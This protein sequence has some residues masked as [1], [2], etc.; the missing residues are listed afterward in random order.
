MGGK[1]KFRRKKTS[2][3]GQGQRRKFSL[4]K[5]PW[6]LVK[7]YV[8]FGLGLVFFF[9]LFA[10]DFFFK[11]VMEPFTAFVALCSSQILNIFGSWT[12]VSGTHL[13]SSDYGINVV[14]GCNGAFATAILLSGII[15][16]PSRIREKLVGV[17]IGIPAI[18]AINQIRVISLFLLG[19]SHP[20]VFEEAHVYVWQPIIIIF[21]ILVWDFWARSFVRKDKVHK[22]AVSA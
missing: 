4:S 15:A 18:F 1:D 10:Q 3:G 12:S 21:A 11:S 19:R 7:I 22:K 6:A 9:A 14:Y 5:I 8:Y 2:S 17:L 16:Y 20:D 13:S